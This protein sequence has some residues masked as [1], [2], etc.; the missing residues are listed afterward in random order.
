M[1]PVRISTRVAGDRPFDL[2]DALRARAPRDRGRPGV[3]ALALEGIDQGAR[4]PGA[5]QAEPQGL[6]IRVVVD[7]VT[8]V[9]GREI[10]CGPRLGNVRHHAPHAVCAG[11][12]HVEIHAPEGVAAPGDRAEETRVCGEIVAGVAVDANLAATDEEAEAQVDGRGARVADLRRVD[13]RAA[14]A[15]TL[16]S[17]HTQVRRA[18]LGLA[19][20]EARGF[21]GTARV[22][23]PLDGRCVGRGGSGHE[24]RAVGREGPGQGFDNCD[25]RG[26]GQAPAR[27]DHTERQAL[28]WEHRRGLLETNAAF[29]QG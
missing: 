25:L 16:A 3:V 14:G 28:D 29:R 26:G 27:R 2:A 8:R 10:R 18:R 6:G 1:D 19:E 13:E 5:Q 23:V 12:G 7:G 22:G 11:S 15:D 9:E 17:Q 24:D 4:L 20:V 21:P